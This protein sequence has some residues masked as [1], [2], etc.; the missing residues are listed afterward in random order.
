[1]NEDTER[2]LSVVLDAY[3]E[4]MAARLLRDLLAS[5]T[6]A[7]R[8]AFNKQVL[9]ALVKRIDDGTWNTVYNQTWEHLSGKPDL[10]QLI[11]AELAT[12]RG[13]ITDRI[14][15]FVPAAI[16]RHLPEVLKRY[17]PDALTG[18]VRDYMKGLTTR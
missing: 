6:A 5:M 4:E 12:Y 7:E 9:A 16:E 15:V 3:G 13:T 8:K 1:M 18:M 10:K 11:A 2:R 14:K 17:V